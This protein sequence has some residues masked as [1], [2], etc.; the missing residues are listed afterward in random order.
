MYTTKIFNEY[1]SGN[2]YTDFKDCK[3]YANL[4]TEYTTNPIKN[5]SSTTWEP[6]DHYYFEPGDVDP[7]KYTYDTIK[8]DDLFTQGN[9]YELY[10]SS[11]INT[12]IQLEVISVDS[13]GILREAILIDGTWDKFVNIAGD[14]TTA[15]NL[16]VTITTRHP[17]RTTIEVIG[18]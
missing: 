10:N 7:Q 6:N 5:L 16:R 8:S 12:G 13:P 9:I 14:Y 2:T 4:T 15:D 1:Y 11:G 3:F 17:I 18:K